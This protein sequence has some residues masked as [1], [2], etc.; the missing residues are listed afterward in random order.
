[1]AIFDHVPPRNCSTLEDD[2]LR[3]VTVEEAE[4]LSPKI[5]TSMS[6]SGD[7]RRERLRADAIS[8]V[9]GAK[10]RSKLRTGSIR[11]KEPI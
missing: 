11:G 1:M 5:E 10:D 8:R 9:S 3:H 2:S 4:K 6:Q 7:A